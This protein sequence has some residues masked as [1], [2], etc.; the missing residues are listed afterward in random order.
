M[1]QKGLLIRCLREGSGYTGRRKILRWR[2]DGFDEANPQP[3]LG[4]PAHGDAMKAQRI[5]RVGS[6]RR[7]YTS[8]VTALLRARINLQH[9]APG[10]VHR[11]SRQA[12][13]RRKLSMEARRL[14]AGV[15]GRACPGS[16]STDPAK[17]FQSPG[18]CRTHA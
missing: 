16:C 9:V 17:F 4:N 3:V 14:G 10:P 15:Q 1:D 13:A 11:M 6:S 8:K 12:V 5:W 7:K 2:V 18:L